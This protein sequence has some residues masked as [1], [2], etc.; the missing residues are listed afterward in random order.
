MVNPNVDIV[1]TSKWKIQFPMLPDG[2]SF[3]I[4]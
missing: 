3:I 1:K 4:S 2:R